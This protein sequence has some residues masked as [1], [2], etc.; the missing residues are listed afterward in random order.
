MTGCIYSSVMSNE[1]F[2]LEAIVGKSN[3]K[4]C[5]QYYY[6]LSSLGFK[7][8]NLGTFSKSMLI[9]KEKIKYFKDHYNNEKILNL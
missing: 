9:S 6:K 3:R 8:T 4:L 7:R 5:S 2:N 1:P